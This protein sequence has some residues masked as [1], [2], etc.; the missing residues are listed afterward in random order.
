MAISQGAQAGKGPYPVGG[1]EA[2]APVRPGNSTFAGTPT[3]STTVNLPVDAQGNAYGAYRF[4]ASGSISFGFGSGPAVVNGA[5]QYLITVGMVL[6]LVPPPG[7]TQYTAFF[8]AA[9][10]T[11]SLC[12]T[13]LY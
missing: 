13:G 4:I 7:T 3:A 12:C 1:A 10:T 8:D 11:G 9:S 5:N 6:D 2:V